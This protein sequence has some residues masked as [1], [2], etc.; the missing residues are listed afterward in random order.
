MIEAGILMPGLPY[1]TWFGTGVYRINRLLILRVTVYSF[2]LTPAKN[3][4]FFP[5][6]SCLQCELRRIC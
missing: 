4:N 1:P 2:L 5:L 3:G 6:G